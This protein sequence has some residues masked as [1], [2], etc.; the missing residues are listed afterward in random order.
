MEFFLGELID[1]LRRRM[2]RLWLRWSLVAVV[3]ILGV[4]SA[5]ADW[6]GALTLAP[7]VDFAPRPR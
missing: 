2:R 4:M 1:W 3:F 6:I 5:V 7:R